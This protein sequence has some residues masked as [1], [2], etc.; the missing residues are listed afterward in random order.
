[1]ILTILLSLMTLLPA[2]A[3][4]S[5]SSSL[6][7]ASSA[8]ASASVS[9]GSVLPPKAEFRGAWISTINQTKYAQMTDFQMMIYFE[10]LLDSLQSAG[11]NV[12]LFQVRPQC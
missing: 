2:S 6:A 3:S 5:A 11:I 8:S 4:A 1:M 10:N 7:S 12:V 9:T